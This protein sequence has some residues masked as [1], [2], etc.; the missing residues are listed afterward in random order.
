MKASVHLSF[1]G[2]CEEAFATYARALG[3]TVTYSLRYRDSPMAS[4]V[5]A[6]WQDK[7]YHATMRIGDLT[8]MGG[9]HDIDYVAPKG[10]MLMLS[11]E[12]PDDARRM[13]A[14]LAKDGSVEMAIQET[15]WSSAFG[16]VVDRFG[17][18]WAINCETPPAEAA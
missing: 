8:L 14:E 13:F 9:D 7:L 11:P 2:T 17:I 16:T 18:T 5:P 1:A 6:D 3:G 15:F 10:F 12:T 4:S